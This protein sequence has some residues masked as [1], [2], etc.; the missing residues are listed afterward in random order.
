MI[1]CVAFSAR[2]LLMFHKGYPP[3]FINGSPQYMMNNYQVAMAVCRY[4][5]NPDLFY[6]FHM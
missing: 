2:L 1:S 3:I 4:Y 6:K 5:G